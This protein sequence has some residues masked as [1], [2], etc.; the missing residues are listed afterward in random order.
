MPSFIKQLFFAYEFRVV[1]YIPT[2]RMANLEN[3]NFDITTQVMEGICKPKRNK[4][5]LF[6]I[7]Y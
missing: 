5:N 7:Q 4:I 3:L 2:Y 1:A 6:R